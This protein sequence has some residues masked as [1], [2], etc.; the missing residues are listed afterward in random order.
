MAETTAGKVKRQVRLPKGLPVLLALL[1]LV[2]GT[3][4]GSYERR[5]HL[6]EK[7][8]ARMDLLPDAA[9]KEGTPNAGEPET[10]P[11]GENFQVVINQLPTM[12]NGRSPCNIQAE[13]P[14]GNHYDLRV[15]LY[16][17][18]TGELLGATHRIERGKRVD[19]LSLDRVLEAGEY[20]VIAEL[21]LFNDDQEQVA[22][23]SVELSLLV[24]A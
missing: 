6:P 13:N 11:D 19:E 16:L 3:F 18:E 2:A 17:A 14:A 8:Q 10:A 1:L 20:P 24:K 5:I 21:E 23:L 9:A 15:C 22:E 12:E 4:Y 7:L